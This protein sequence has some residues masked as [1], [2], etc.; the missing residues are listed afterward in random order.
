M[1]EKVEGLRRTHNCGEL[2]ASNNGDQVTLC[3]WVSKYRDLGGLHFIDLRDKYGLTQLGFEDFKGNLDLLKK[4]SLES[5]IKIRGIVAKRPD[6]SLNKNMP[7]GEVEV[8]VAELEVLSQSDVDNM[9]FFPDGKVN[10]TEDQRLKYRYL[11]LRTKKLQETLLLRSNAT[12]TT[13][14]YMVENGF[15][16][17]E[18]PILYKSTP[19]GARDYIVPSRV[20]AGEVYALP[21]SPQTLKQLL[22][23]GG[24]DKY[25]QICRCFRDE[26]L[27]AD[28]QPEFSQIDIEASFSTQKYL[29]NLITGL[30][31]KLFK[32]E[33]NFVVPSMTYDEAMARYGSDKPDIRFGLEH[34]NCTDFFKTTEFKVFQDPATRGGLIKAFFVP[35]SMGSFSRKDTDGFVEVVKPYGG[36]GVAFYKVKE[37]ERSAGISKFIT[38]EIHAELEKQ[39][40]ESDEKNGTWLFFSDRDPDVSHASAD[41]L[42]RHLGNKLELKK[43]GYHFLW[44]YDFP[45][46]EYSAKDNRFLAKHHP[47]TSPKEELIEDFLKADPTNPD[48]TLKNMAA[49]AYDLVCNGYELGGGSIRIHRN[50]VQTKMF[51]VLGF[52]EEDAQKQFGFFLEAL[53]YGTPPHGGI[54]LGL[55]RLVM[56]LVKSENIRDVIAFPKTT[57][58]SDLM[59]SSPSKPS[60]AQIKELHFKWDL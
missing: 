28:R 37:G 40:T 55:D 59:A 49:E 35:E 54:A 45:L 31:V 57:T 36:K 47:F 20:R 34:I 15:I 42:R 56:L 21:Q 13:R 30:V 12:T 27:R 39:Y 33:D 53:R 19:E 22:M 6:T 11:D 24:T 16:E 43:E 2:R 25:F 58:A 48:G 29:K 41:A 5:V 4:C 38:D 14:N 7:T 46:L 60:D 51:Q 18:T 26:D 23:I 52:T 9:P 8:Q 3:G 10:A 50:D 17:V 32:L 1:I 44:V